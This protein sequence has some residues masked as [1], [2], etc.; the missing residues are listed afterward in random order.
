MLPNYLYIQE[1]HRRMKYP[2]YRLT[3]RHRIVVMR[4]I[5]EVCQYRSWLLRAAHVRSTHLHAVISGGS[6]PEPIQEALKAYSSR[7][8]NRTGFD[9]PR[10]KRWTRHGSNLYLWTQESVDA[11]IRYVVDSQ[12]APM[13]VYEAK[14]KASDITEP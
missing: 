3:K 14:N 6:E 5:L 1:S 11:T 2:S 9:P 13:E 4:T 12:G 8:L 7:N 10:P